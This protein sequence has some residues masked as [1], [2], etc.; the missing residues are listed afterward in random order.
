M[1]MD[2][3]LRRAVLETLALRGDG[4]GGYASLAVDGYTRTEV[5]SALRSLWRDG[6]IDAWDV[7]GGL[8]D[9]HESEV[10]P[11]TLTPTGRA[12]LEAI[13]KS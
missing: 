9:I 8:G 4:P 7:S 6:L 12:H 11:S 3:Q 2:T 1:T 5:Q 10:E 13:R